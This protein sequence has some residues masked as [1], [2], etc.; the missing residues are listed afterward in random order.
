MMTMAG[1]SPEQGPPLWVPLRFFF[2]APLA[3]LAAGGLL[4]LRGDEGV[5]NQWGPTS[6]AVAHLGT[7]GFL[8]FVMLGALYQMLPVVAGAVVPWVRLAHGVHGL[9]VAGAATLVYGQAT[10]TPRAFSVA[11][12]LLS[13]AVLLFLVPA[14]LAMLRR[15]ASGP[16]PLGLALALVGLGAVVFAGARLALVR[17]GHSNEAQW[18]SL[19]AAHVHLG[20][21]LWVGALII[22][23]SW[24]VL[25]MFFLA[26]APS[27]AVSRVTQALSAL[28]LVGLLVA[29]AGVPAGSVPVLALPGAVATWVLQPAWAVKALRARKRRRRDATLW[30]W[31]LGLSSAPV[32]LVLG[33]ATAWL[34]DERWA[35]TYGVVVLWGWAGAIAHGMLT[36]IVPF[37]VW[38]HR[39]APLVGRVKVPTVKELLPDR[40]VALGFW[41]HGAG[42]VAGV[43]ACWV[44][45]GVAWRVFGLALLSTGG[46][47]GWVL[48]RARLRGTVT[49]P[50]APSAPST[51]A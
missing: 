2:T 30:F 32:C 43:V 27:T 22:S 20:F 5:G 40:A 47:L 8:L 15:G 17:G 29:L 6:L 1:L 36:R 12:V 48:T 18:L 10:A 14:G 46:W 51:R 39:C 41:L 37:L 42:L 21:L 35:L 23:V 11:A 33:G 44:G 9:L 4:L 50:G 26:P 3:L 7:V 31:W 24:Q 34:D 49:S 13:A 38:L 28:S 19:R 45:T 16:T 25:P